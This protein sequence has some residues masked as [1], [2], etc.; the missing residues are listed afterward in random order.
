MANKE[1]FE[2]KFVFSSQFRKAGPKIWACKRY[3]IPGLG[4]C[5]CPGGWMYTL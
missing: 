4:R 2:P 5:W 1:I 3:I